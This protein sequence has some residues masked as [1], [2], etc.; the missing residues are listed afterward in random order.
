M[1]LHRKHQ[2]FNV[3]PILVL[4]FAKAPLME[5]L[6][7]LMRTIQAGIVI[8]RNVQQET[9]GP[10]LISERVIVSSKLRSLHPLMAAELTIYGCLTPHDYNILP[11]IV[12][13]RRF[14]AISFIPPGR[15]GLTLILRILLLLPVSMRG[16]G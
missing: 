4:V 1:F 15:L 13:L 10:K 12:H 11:I 9:D 3:L 6:P 8:V 14:P 16:T 5:T 7:V 2:Q